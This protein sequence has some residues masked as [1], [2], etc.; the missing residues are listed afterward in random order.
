M[1]EYELDID[2]FTEEELQQ[3][4]EEAHQ[5][6]QEWNVNLDEMI[7]KLSDSNKIFL[8][9]LYEDCGEKVFYIIFGY[10]NSDTLV[11][12]DEM[13]EN[14]VTK[15]LQELSEIYTLNFIELLIEFNKQ[16]V[17]LTEQEVDFQKVIAK[18]KRDVAT[19][20]KK[21]AQP[22]KYINT[23]QF[24]ERYSLTKIQQ[25]NLRTRHEYSLP[26]SIVNSRVL[27]E[28]EII[29]KWMENYREQ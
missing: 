10:L 7:K 27:Y 1:D 17:E 20:K 11:E 3:F 6:Y 29:D 18:L 15:F 22:S 9:K 13:T 2:D 28:P 25:K 5:E 8:D 12:Y 26:Y 16:E 24:E 14:G 19:L 23:T 21:V 4:A